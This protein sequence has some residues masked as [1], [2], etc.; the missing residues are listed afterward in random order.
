MACVTVGV[1]LDLKG[2]SLSKDVLDRYE[3]FKESVYKCGVQIAFTVVILYVGF[4]KKW[5][6]DPKL[7]Y[8]ECFDIPCVTQSVTPGERFIYRFELA[9]YS[10]A[11]P[12]I[13][14]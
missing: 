6:W 14:L 10:Q 12:M 8:A 1:P 4:Q 9:F 2:K 7:C 3:K 13:F 11:I 5:F